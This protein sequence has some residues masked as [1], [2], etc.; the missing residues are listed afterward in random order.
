MRSRP[1]QGA[2]NNTFYIIKSG[3]AKV[4]Q[5]KGTPRELAE[6]EEQED[7]FIVVRDDQTDER[8]RLKSRRLWRED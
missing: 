2:A 3:A 5:E 1:A 4:R 6:L 8:G 7:L